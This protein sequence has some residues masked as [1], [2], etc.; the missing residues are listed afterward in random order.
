MLEMENTALLV[1]DVQG[2]L[3]YQVY[4]SARILENLQILIK[5]ARVFELPVLAVEQYPQGLGPTVPEVGKLFQDTVP[6]EKIT[7][8]ACLNEAFVQKLEECGKKQLLVAGI[9]THVCVYQTV[10]GLRGRSYEVHVAADAV[11]SRTAWNRETALQRMRELGAV[12]TTTEMALFE[13]AKIAE[14]ERFRR[15]IEIVK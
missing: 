10:T 1:I 14:G 5:S 4:R 8:N 15:F 13:L 6:V 9:E 7:F 2:K 12:I 11:S 3:A